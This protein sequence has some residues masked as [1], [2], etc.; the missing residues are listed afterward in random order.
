LYNSCP[1]V[2]TRRVDLVTELNF[3]LASKEQS[4]KKRK[5][6]RNKKTIITEK[7]I[8]NTKKILAI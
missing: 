3:F 7:Q 5:C 6:I 1:T 8:R 4:V 2:S